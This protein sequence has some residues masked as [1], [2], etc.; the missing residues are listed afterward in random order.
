V[1]IFAI[2]DG[3]VAEF[4][5]AEVHVR[6]TF[7]IVNSISRSTTAFKSFVSL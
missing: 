1:F 4:A 6:G 2:V 3:A 7:S 5:G